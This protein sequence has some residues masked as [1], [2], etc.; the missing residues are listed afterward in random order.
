M[1]PLPNV[2]GVLEID[3]RFTLGNDT[4][5]N[6]KLHFAYTGGPASAAQLT[7]L[8]GMIEAQC[9]SHVMPQFISYAVLNQLTV[10]DLSDRTAPLG[11]WSG[12]TP[13]VLGGNMNPAS[14]CVVASYHISRRYRGGHPRG[15]WPM[16]NQAQNLTAGSWNGTFIGNC[17]AALQAYVAAVTGMV[18]GLT[19]ANQVAISYYH[20]SSPYTRPNG[21]TAYRATLR[22]NPLIDAVSGITCS[23][24]MGSQRRR[25]KKA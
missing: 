24:R 6:T 3:H 7:T 23:S 19:V 15:Y 11:V 1:T 4:N 17:T 10:Q 2:P 16:G 8:A 5:V 20:G 13:G 22:A 9:A 12:N 21:Q 25:L 14:I 18:S